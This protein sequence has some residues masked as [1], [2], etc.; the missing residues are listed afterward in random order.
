MSTLAQL[1]QGVGHAWDS[2]VDG[3]QHLYQSASAAL[4]RFRPGSGRSASSDQ[5]LAERSSGWGLLAA[6]VFDGDKSIT[7]RL[8]APGMEPDDF[9]LEVVNDVL[10]VRGQKRVEKERSEGRYRILECA[11]GSFERAIP[12]PENI[13][14]ENTRAT[15]KHGVLK[16]ELPKLAPAREHTIRVS[17]Q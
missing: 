15:Y 2:L 16:V 5:D 11:Y 8:E 7:L 6:E 3:W 4:T 13:D 12:L 1:R 9:E 14:P 17:V 10:V